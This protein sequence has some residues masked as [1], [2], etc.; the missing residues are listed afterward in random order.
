MV[1]EG[2]AEYQYQIGSADGLSDSQLNF[3]KAQWSLFRAWW[4]SWEGAV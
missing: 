3:L 1:L 2:H 4:S